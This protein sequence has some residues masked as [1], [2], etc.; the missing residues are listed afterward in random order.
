MLRRYD[1]KRPINSSE[2]LDLSTTGSDLM[3]RLTQLR[4]HLHRSAERRR[5]L[6]RLRA[7][8]ADYRTPA[9]RAELDAIF[10][11]YDTTV[12]ELVTKS[13]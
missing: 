7:E 3:T 1:T 8:L 5:R 4:D 13:H 12:S 11:R 2:P 6:R 10:A 9:E